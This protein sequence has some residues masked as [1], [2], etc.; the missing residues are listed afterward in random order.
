MKETRNRIIGHRKVRAGDLLVNEH[1][2]R[3]HPEDQKNAIE[4]L[5]DEVGFARSLL[6]YELPDGSLKLLDGHLRRE[7][8]PDME[9]DV[10]VLDVNETEANKLLLSID[11]LVGM[12]KMNEDMQQKLVSMVRTRS[13]ELGLLWNE[14]R[15]SA[16][17][18]AQL[19]KRSLERAKA[20]QHIPNQ[21]L[22]IVE[23]E[24]EEEQLQVLEDLKSQ[25]RKVAAKTC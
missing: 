18:L 3:I 20:I 13:S 11:P 5:Y 25:G 22:V 10:E 23:C 15:K 9:V 4:A 24:D 6:A 2:F 1:N 8:D 21:Y 12:A 17:R 7:I 19:R 16:S 14:S